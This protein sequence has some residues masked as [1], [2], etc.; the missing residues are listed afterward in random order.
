MPIMRVEICSRART[1]IHEMDFIDLLK[2]IFRR[3]NDA[4]RGYEK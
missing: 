1:D 4:W 3:L 2:G